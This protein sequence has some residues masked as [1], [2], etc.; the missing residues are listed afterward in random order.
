MADADMEVSTA[1]LFDELPVLDPV[2]CHERTAY[3]WRGLTAEGEVLEVEN[4]AAMIPKEISV[5]RA[6]IEIGRRMVGNEWPVDIDEYLHAFNCVVD[7][8]KAN[9][10]DAAMHWANATVRIAPTLRA[11]FNR[12][13]MLLAGGAWREGLEEYWHCEQR[14]PFMRPQVREALDHGLK[15]WRGE[16]LRGKRLLVMHAH[17]F[18][19]TLQMLRYLPELEKRGAQI[20]LDVP[21]ELGR[22]VTRW[23]EPDGDYDYFCPLLHLLY[24][25]NVTPD[26]VDGASYLDVEQS[27]RLPLTR[28]RRVGLAWSIGKPSDGDYPRQIPLG[29]LVA[30][31]PDCE[32]HSVQ[33]QGA[34]EA[35]VLGVQTHAFRDFADCAALMMAMDEIVSVDTAALHLAGA[36]GHPRVFG[37]LSHWASW[38]WCARWYDNVTLCRQTTPGDWASALARARV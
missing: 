21:P 31:F 14:A 15:P 18:G 33:T 12:A 6:G 2:V 19:D 4:K 36:I 16:D 24:F 20:M 28:K 34:A 1:S 27:W 10:I 3:G 25:L 29:Q 32:L 8:Y 17:G 26:E 13:M 37:L 7:F 35:Q 30:A 38:R 9:K 23:A 11:R 5:A 22:L